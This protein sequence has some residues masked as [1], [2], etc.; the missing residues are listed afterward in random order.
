MRQKILT[1]VDRSVLVLFSLL[2]GITVISAGLSV[3]LKLT[4]V[5]LWSVGVLLIGAGHTC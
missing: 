5:T 3:N 1:G 4:D 2:F